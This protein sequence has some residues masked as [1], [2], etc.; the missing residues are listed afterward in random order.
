M[1]VDIKKLHKALGCKDKLTDDTAE[2]TLLGGITALIGKADTAIAASKTAT[3][4]LKE[5][6]KA[7][8][9][10]PDPVKVT[11]P[12]EML[13]ALSRKDRKR[14]I[15]DLV[16]AGKI[17][18]AVATKLETQFIG[19]D[20]KALVLSLKAGD[21]GTFDGVMSALAENDPVKL[22]E[23]TKAQTLSLSNPNNSPATGAPSKELSEEM[24]A[25]AK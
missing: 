7:G 16:L 20:D 25:L 15:G 19:E 12:N 14:E 10:E 4:A 23:Q 13:V 21:L 3:A 5:L 11:E 2:E 17:T 1:E 8:V 22:G 24:A 18:P 6:K 9:K